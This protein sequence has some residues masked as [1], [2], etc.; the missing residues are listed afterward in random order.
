V[1]K[2]RC[3]VKKGFTLMELIIVVVIIGILAM[4]GL[5]QFFRVAERG[6]A[7][8]GIALLGSIRNAQL[9]FAAERGATTGNVADLDINIPAAAQ[10]RFFGAPQLVAGVNPEAQPGA[11][12]AQVARTAVQ[13]Q[14]GNNY[15]LSIQANGIFVCAGGLAGTCQIVRPR[16]N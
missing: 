15:V 4:V 1:Q 9:R 6:R 3:F 14:A 7:A 13:N 10:L 16:E 2:R 11:V 5:P 8:E 12:I